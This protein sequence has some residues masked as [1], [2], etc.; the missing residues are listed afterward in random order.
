M[1]NLVIKGQ[2]PLAGEIAVSGSKNA[3]L[4]ILAATLLTEAPCVIHNVP[5]LRDTMTMIKLLRALG[6][7]VDVQKDT[8]TVT[9]KGPLNHIAEYDLVSTMRGSFCV[10]GPLLARLGHAQVSL[11]G[12]CVIGIRPVDL[13][14]KGLRGLGAQIDIASGYVVARAKRLKGR[15]LYLGGV[16][17]SSVLATAN[18]M[19]AAVLGQ[20][21]TIIESAACE[22]EIVDLAN[23][24][25]AMG[26]DITGQGSPRIT[27]RGVRTLQGADYPICCDRI[28]AGTYLILAAATRSN[29]TIHNVPAHHV[30]ALIDKLQDAG[31]HFHCMDQTITVQV[32]KNLQPV[33][34]TTYP[35]PGFPTDLQAQFM[36][37]MALTPGVSVIIDK[38]F[39]DRFIHIAELN[40]MGARIRREGS[41]AIVEG[42]KKLH[43]AP[44]MASDLRASAA[45]VIAGIAAE[46]ETEISR[47]YHLDRGYESL[48]DKLR[49]LGAQIKRVR[50]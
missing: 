32:K 5:Q 35:Y 30:L 26:A 34:V 19:M 1:E 21:S 33:S 10:L 9:Q 50:T 3:A 36:A 29:L 40:R 13:H 2:Q 49:K 42:V 27:I 24:L 31:V 38:V 44:V 43:G 39:P 7:K 20:G 45:L 47:I 25:I 22:P 6:K 37:L 8:L 48:D 15:H 11:P 18:I 23:F 28:E 4:P 17:G 46:G 14:L 16:L 41:A 12:G